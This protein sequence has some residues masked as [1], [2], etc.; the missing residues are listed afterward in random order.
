MVKLRLFLICA[1]LALAAAPTQAGPTS[2]LIRPGASVG[3]LSIG[4][5]T[6]AVEKV[7]GKPNSTYREAGVLT[8]EYKGKMGH[9]NLGFQE[10]TG[11]LTSI[12]CYD[13][14]FQVAGAAEVKVSCSRQAVM[15]A[16]PKPDLD[17]SE[18][19]DYNN[20]GIYFYFNSRSSSHSLPLY[21]P[22]LAEAIIVY[23]PGR[24]EWTK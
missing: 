18:Q 14:A 16:F 4:D 8:W 2:K 21:G 11:K 13:P 15:K 19:L 24:S 22:G 1:F 23:R 7:W 3:P 6:Q 17:N 5:T 10:K 12:A 20:L 9:L